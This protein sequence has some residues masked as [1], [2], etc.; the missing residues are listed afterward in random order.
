MRAGFGVII[1][2]NAGFYLS[3]FF[4]YINDSLTSCMLI[5]TLSTKVLSW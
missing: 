4:D 3:D 2:N 1:R 5:Y